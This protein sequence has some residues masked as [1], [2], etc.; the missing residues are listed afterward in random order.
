MA[1]IDDLEKR[2]LKLILFRPDSKISKNI[3]LFGILSSFGWMLL[4]SRPFDLN[5]DA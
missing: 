1:N 5:A 4:K 3:T 2:R